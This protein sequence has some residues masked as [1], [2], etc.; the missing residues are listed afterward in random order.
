MLSGI[1]WPD[2]PKERN[3]LEGICTECKDET[4]HHMHI[5]TLEER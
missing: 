5:I 2:V 1:E 3:P 4:D